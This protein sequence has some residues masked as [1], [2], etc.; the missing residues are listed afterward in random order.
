MTARSTL[1]EQLQCLRRGQAHAQTGFS[2]HGLHA[3]QGSLLVGSCLL[4]AMLAAGRRRLLLW[5]AVS[6]LL[7]ASALVL[8]DL[9]LTG[10]P[11]LRYLAWRQFVAPSPAWDWS[12][13]V[14]D[15]GLRPHGAVVQLWWPLPLAGALVLAQAALRSRVLSPRPRDAQGAWW[16]ADRRCG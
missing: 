11:A 14:W 5:S 3:I 9:A 6:L 7:G 10:P 12:R 1:A 2:L 13:L 15:T 8:V 16:P 4:L